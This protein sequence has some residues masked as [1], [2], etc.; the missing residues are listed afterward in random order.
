MNVKLN[1]VLR[2]VNESEET[3]HELINIRPLVDGSPPL[4][5]GGWAMDPQLGKILAQVISRQR[6][7]WIV[8]CGSGSS[9]VF[10][11]YCLR[12]IE[13]EGK[14]TAFEHMPEY[15]DKTRALVEA[16]GVSD[17]VE[18][19]TAP[20]ERRT[21]DGRDWSW[22]GVDPH[23][24]S[25]RTI[26]LL[27]VDGPPHTT[28]TQARYPAIPVLREHLSE[29]CVI[30]LDDADRPEEK[31]VARLWGDELEARV[32]YRSGGTGTCILRLQ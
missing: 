20:L 10:M 1:H 30:V 29:D 4:D 23:S 28:G 8:E 21:I 6:P 27:V 14:V 18:V 32:E 13:G 24:F 3:L 2:R 25:D 15:A 7:G 5:Y 31:E 26:D 17:C 19:I 16:H 9:T 22:Y 12:R 11:G